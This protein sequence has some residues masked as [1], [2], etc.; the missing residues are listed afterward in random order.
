MTF[1]PDI[2]DTIESTASDYLQRNNKLPSFVTLS[3]EEYKAY[4][5]E[6]RAG[7]MPKI[8]IN[9]KTVILSVRRFS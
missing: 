7:R 5:E 2:I 6:R 1:E 8:R 3:S 4:E 9:G